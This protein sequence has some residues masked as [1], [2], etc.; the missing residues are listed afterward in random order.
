MLA[1]VGSSD[2]RAAMGAFASGVTVITTID[3]GGIPCGLTA[4]ALASVCREPPT[5]LVCVAKMAE[6]F[7]VILTTKKF[8]VNILSAAQQGVSMAFATSGIDKFASVRW[9][10]GPALGCPIFPDALTSFECVLDASLSKGDHDVL[11]GVLHSVQSSEDSPLLY[12][13][14]RYGDVVTRPK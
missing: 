1:P 8:A 3:P 10:K 2:F 9:E 6:A 13:R 4:T 11:F 7:P 12:F 5:C 14:G